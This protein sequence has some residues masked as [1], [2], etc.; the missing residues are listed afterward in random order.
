MKRVRYGEAE[1]PGDAQLQ[2][3]LDLRRNKAVRL[4]HIAADRAEVDRR[5]RNI[6]VGKRSRMRRS[7]PSTSSNGGTRSQSPG[8]RARGSSTSLARAINRQPRGSPYSLS[9]I[10]QID[11]D[12]LIWRRLVLSADSSL[13][14]GASRDS[15]RYS[16]KATERL[17]RAGV[18]SGRNS[19]TLRPTFSSTASKRSGPH[20]K[21]T[22]GGACNSAVDVEERRDLGNAVL[23]AL[24]LAA[25]DAAKQAVGG[26]VGVGYVVEEELHR[27]RCRV[28]VDELDQRAAEPGHGGRLVGVGALEAVFGRIEEDGDALSGGRTLEHLDIGFLERH[29]GPRSQSA[30]QAFAAE[31][32]VDP[33]HHLVDQP[34]DVGKR[35]QR[36]RDW[37]RDS[38]RDG[39]RRLARDRGEWR[40]RK[41]RQAGLDSRAW[42]RRPDELGRP[43]AAGR[44]S[45]ADHGLAAPVDDGDDRP[46]RRGQRRRSIDAR[47]GGRRVQPAQRRCMRRRRA[48]AGSQASRP[49]QPKRHRC[50]P[51]RAAPTQTIAHVPSAE[52]GP[53]GG[54]PEGARRPYQA[55]D[56][57]A[58]RRHG[59]NR[60]RR[61][62]ASKRRR[63]GSRQRRH[64]QRATRGWRTRRLCADSPKLPRRK[65]RRLARRFG[66]GGPPPR[67]D[68][69]RGRNRRR[70]RARFEPRRLA[71]AKDDLL[72]EAKAER[73][74]CHVRRLG[75]AAAPGRL[76]PPPEQAQRR[77]PADAPA[78]AVAPADHRPQQRADAQRGT[79]FHAAPI[80]AKVGRSRR[81]WCAN[82]TISVATC[83][84]AASKSA[85][86]HLTG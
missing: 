18:P 39:D 29:P 83:P 38:R 19:D 71:K 73:P 81:P 33:A 58:A 13:I 21:R 26:A 3:D 80:P 47:R 20:T 53:G 64:G 24:P 7:A 17:A 5:R 48:P 40:Q 51:G 4:A 32:T 41:R 75:R 14:A 82:S 59:R 62:P 60:H 2:V 30:P 74:A 84:D 8:R 34:V 28:A 79:R 72:Q 68:R 37:R 56:R 43:A 70:L 6:E 9:A 27:Q 50:V 57:K 31:P 63:G 22:G 16:R 46:V 36:R 10:S 78:S 67:R 23:D 65:D 61:R 69:R 55:A 11:S 76:A 15:G 35:R 85:T 52:A 49:V 86:D 44:R 25:A 54:A 66:A 1:L 12:A 45:I 42:R 77:P